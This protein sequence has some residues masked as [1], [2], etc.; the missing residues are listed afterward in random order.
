M[1]LDGLLHQYLR[2]SKDDSDI[3]LSNLRKSIKFAIINHI[4]LQKNQPS[5]ADFLFCRMVPPWGIEPQPE[6]PESSI[7]SI[8]LREH[9][10]LQM[11]ITHCLRVS[12]RCYNATLQTPQS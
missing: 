8:K 7:L 3:Y 5:R 4:F 11:R 6:E 2:V 10:H 1:V 9:S 12:C